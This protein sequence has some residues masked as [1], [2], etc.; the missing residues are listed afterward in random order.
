MTCATESSREGAR[1]QGPSTVIPAAVRAHAQ[2]LC[3]KDLRLADH[4]PRCTAGLLWALLL[5][6]ASRVAS[7][8]VTCRVLLRAP[9]D[10]DVQDALLA[11]CH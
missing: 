8:A 9:S 5:Y 10:S 1:C 7:P 11:P 2:V 4:G 6:A 3:R